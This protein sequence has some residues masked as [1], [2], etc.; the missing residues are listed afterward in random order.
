VSQALVFTLIISLLTLLIFGLWPAI[1]TS[2]ANINQVLKEGGRTSAGRAVHGRGSGLLVVFQ[3]TISLVL[4]IGATL[5]LKSF[6]P[7][8]RRDTGVDSQN[9]V[10]MLLLS[11]GHEPSF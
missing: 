2:K 4:L 11:Q 5:M 6:A 8:L 3:I 7:L 9:L 10:A 1:R